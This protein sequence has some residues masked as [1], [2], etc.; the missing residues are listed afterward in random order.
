MI[1]RIAA[2]LRLGERLVLISHDRPDGDALGSMLALA[3]A[4]RAQGKTARVVCS[5]VPRAYAFLTAGETFVHP[6]D[7]EFVRRQMAEM[8]DGHSIDVEYRILKG[9]DDDGRENET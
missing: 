2:R 8:S 6:D 9:G 5:G 4:A 1:E 7:R 3:Q